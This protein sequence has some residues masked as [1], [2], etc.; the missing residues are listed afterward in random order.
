MASKQRMVQ[1]LM[2]LTAA[3]QQQQEAAKA[4]SEQQPLA[5]QQARLVEAEDRVSRLQQENEQL[6]RAAGARAAA[7][8]GAEAAALHLDLAAAAQALGQ[9]GGQWGASL[10]VNELQRKLHRTEGEL[11]AKEASARRYKDAVRVLK[12]RVIQCET[13]LRARQG[14]LTELQAL[15]QLHSAAAKSNLPPAAPSSAAGPAPGGPEAERLRQEADTAMRR[16]ADAE[17]RLLEAQQ[18]LQKLNAKLDD[19]QVESEHVVRGAQQHVSDLNYRLQHAERE[20]QDLR[21]QLQRCEER[22]AAS[23]KRV[24]ERDG[25]LA[26]VAAQLKR[27]QTAL[28][29][30]QQDA[31]SA[32]RHGRELE[33]LLEAMQ[34]QKREVEADA[35]MLQGRAADAEQRMADA[36][37]HLSYL[38]QRLQEAELQARDYQGKWVAAEQGRGQLEVALKRAEAES[39]AAASGRRAELLKQQAAAELEQ[40]QLERECQ[41]LQ[42][43]LQLLKAGKAAADQRLA[44]LQAALVAR[45]QALAALHGDAGS[46]HSEKSHL[47]QRISL[48]E[49]RVASR[50]RA[51]RELADHAARAAAEHERHVA[52]LS[53]EL[54]G[55]SSALAD[56]E[57]R[58]GELE[59]LMQRMASR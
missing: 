31:D 50:D 51:A 15:L 55:K 13:E 40:C 41:A 38:T 5:A 39:A 2:A 6:R 54:A 1:Q 10:I 53:A 20:A 56:A 59:A 47:S 52:A 43:E 30:A 58:F 18:Q 36:G 19:L 57:R 21:R 45:D 16:A 48:L 44:E 12:N 46:W 25:E 29:A 14:Q 11:E 34:R 8:H 28:A 3:A 35:H 22:A 33:A 32:H 23:D 37:N 17:G 7:P 4:A 26:S 24:Q 27:T 49:E 9:P 42:Q